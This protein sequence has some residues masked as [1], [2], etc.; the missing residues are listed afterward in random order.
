M[1]WQGQSIHSRHTQFSLF[2]PLYFLYI[3]LYFPHSL[4]TYFSLSCM[5]MCEDMVYMYVIMCV[6]IHAFGVRG[7][8]GYWSSAS[9]LL[10]F[11]YCSLLCTQVSWHKNFQSS[12]V[13][14]SHITKDA[15]RSQTYSADR[16]LGGF[17]QLKHRIWCCT[18]N[19]LPTKESP[20]SFSF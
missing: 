18:E 12:I 5:C 11:F 10:T 6:S 19:T 3:S 8:C 17:W 16:L 13:S 2:S 4:L 7:N 14:A 20:Q 9:T 15:Q 1:I